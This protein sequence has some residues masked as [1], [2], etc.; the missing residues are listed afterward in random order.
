MMLFIGKSEDSEEPPLFCGNYAYF[1]YMHPPMRTL[2]V[3]LQ[4]SV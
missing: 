2:L 1:S 3:P 4:S